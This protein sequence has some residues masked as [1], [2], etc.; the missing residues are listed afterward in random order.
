MAG[1]RVLFDNV[2]AGDVARHEVRRE[3]DALEDQ[4]E[5]LRQGAHQQGLGGARQ[6][7]D[8]AMAAHEQANHDLLQHLL[9]A[10]DHAANLR[11]DV[12]LHLVEA[13][14][15]LFQSLGINLRSRGC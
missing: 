12:G 3:L 7:G 2:G 13:L 15:A 9:L 11:H 14:D 5:G 8:Q 1:G 10:H 4:A 6:A